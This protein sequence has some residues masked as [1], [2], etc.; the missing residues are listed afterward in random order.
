M[1]E[2][3]HAKP[4]SA[5]SGSRDRDALMRR[6]LALRELAEVTRATSQALVARCVE[7]RIAREGVRG[8]RWNSD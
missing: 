2:G 7:G 4:V 1:D 8:R 6:V 5:P 3:F